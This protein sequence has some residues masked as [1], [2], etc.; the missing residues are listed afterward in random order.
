MKRSPSLHSEQSSLSDSKHVSFNQD[1]SVKRIP[2]KPIKA[3]RSVPLNP[4]DE[5]SGRCESFTNIP[6]PS[7]QTQIAEEAEDILKQLQE[8]K[9]SVSANP[10]ELKRVVSPTRILT[11]SRVLSPTPLGRIF[12]SNPHLNQRA[13]PS[14]FGSRQST[15]ERRPFLGGRLSKSSSDLIQ[16]NP[17]M[18]V[19]GFSEQEDC[20]SP[21]DHRLYGLQALSKLDNALNGKVNNLYRDRSVPADYS[22]SPKKNNFTPPKPP[23]KA[24]S[25]SPPNIRKGYNSLDELEFVDRRSS[26]YES[27]IPKYNMD[28]YPNSYTGTNP[29]LNHLRGS[30]ARFSP[31]SRQSPS[32][33]NHDKEILSSPSQVLYATISADKNK[34]SNLKN[35][36]TVHSSSQTVQSGFRPVSSE[37]MINSRTL[38]KEN[39]LDEPPY[40][41]GNNTTAPP[42]HASRSLER[43]VD[44]DKENRRQEL[45]ARIHVTS[46]HRFSPDRAVSRKPYKTTINTA[47]D[48]IQYRGFS[49]ENL[50][51]ADR[52]QRNQFKHSG[53]RMDTE[54]YKVP[55]NPAPVPQE[56]LARRTRRNE[57]DA[58]N[59][60]NTE[61]QFAST[62]LVRNAE[63]KKGLGEYDREGRRIHT[64]RSG[65]R[66]RAYSGYS[67]SPEREIS[68]DRFIK[69]KSGSKQHVSNHRSPSSSPTRPPRTRGTQGEH[70][71]PVRREH[72]G[73]RVERTPSTRA[74]ATSRSPIKK[75]QRVHNEIQAEQPRGISRLSK[76]QSSR[77]LPGSRTLTLSRERP[78]GGA[79]LTKTLLKTPRVEKTP[80]AE[81]RFSKFTEYRG[82]GAESSSRVGRRSS[83]SVGD[84]M[85]VEPRSRD[86]DREIMERERGQSVPPGANIDSMRDFY[87]TSQFRSMYHLPPNPSRPAPVLDRSN[88][89]V[90]RP[91]RRERTGD[92]LIPPPRRPTRTSLSEGEL[93]DDAARQERVLRQRN[94]FI[95]NFASKNGEILRR[96]DSPEKVQELRTV[97]RGGEGRRQGSREKRPAPQP[98]TQR[99]RRSSVEVLET[100]ESESPRIEKVG[101]K[102]CIHNLS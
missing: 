46:P 56:L 19:E 96:A 90:E 94:K 72:S 66:T 15:L 74:A 9:C 28:L 95:N 79:R 16:P 61:R 62:S 80:E 75:I 73:R 20:P 85:Q 48:T 91:L 38:S 18:R 88:K 69:H 86:Q 7:D 34:N 64:D 50:K 100:S 45:K 3:T 25:S 11:P 32:R 83:H 60:Q 78:D 59:H 99:I 41:F 63:K 53:K 65:E 2:K 4:T 30:P 12:N 33:S 82:D 47:N 102:S 36:H 6:P 10:R 52:Q 57:S 27:D 84:R 13:S 49:T 8:I 97:Y 43:F 5:F 39:I 76:E 67:T 37:R 87:K 93:T 81:D 51:E 35:Q 31:T 55:K 23:R 77:T 26:M 1:V 40:R 89:T 92:A 42:T 101:L 58:Y 24:P 54:H 71:V 17:A 29:N 22:P 68:P 98:P 44:S 14:P 70:Q 21:A